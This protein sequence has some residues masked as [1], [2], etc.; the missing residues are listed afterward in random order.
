MVRFTLPR[1]R[2]VVSHAICVRGRC[3]KINFVRN[4]IYIVGR[5]PRPGTGWMVMHLGGKGRRRV[6]Y[7]QVRLLDPIPEVSL[8]KATGF[9]LWPYTESPEVFRFYCP[10]D[11]YEPLRHAPFDRS[12]LCGL[13]QGLAEGGHPRRAAAV[14]RIVGTI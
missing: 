4:H 1:G 13:A 5:Q 7:S 14:R 12:V 8:G 9:S 2:R 10:E 6:Y 3:Y 11:W